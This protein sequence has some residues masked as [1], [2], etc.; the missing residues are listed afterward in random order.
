MDDASSSSLYGHR[1]DFKKVDVN[2]IRLAG[3]S[4]RN[5]Q[6]FLDKGDVKIRVLVDYIKTEKK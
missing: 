3:I 4:L 6:R 1:V 2:Q 5:E